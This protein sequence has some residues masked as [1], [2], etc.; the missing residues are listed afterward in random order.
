MTSVW[1]ACSIRS[2]LSTPIYNDTISVSKNSEIMDADLIAALQ[3]AFINIGNTDAGKEVIKI[4]SHNGYQ[5][6][7]ASD[8]D[9][10]RAAQK[11]VQEL[12]AAN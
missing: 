9:N 4:Y 6:A 3:Q 12:T 8:Y 10:E 2:R 1:R 5:V 7:Q 11:L